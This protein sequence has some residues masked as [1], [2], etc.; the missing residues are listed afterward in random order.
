VK[1]KLFNKNIKVFA[2]PALLGI[3]ACFQLVI[4]GYPL[5]HDW[6]FELVRIVEYHEALSSGQVLPLWGGD[7]YR[8]FGSPIFIFYAPLYTACS[9]LLMMT[10]LSV[11]SAATIVLIFFSMLAAIGMAG[12][13]RAVLGRDKPGTDQASWVASAAYV[14]MPYFLADMLIRNASA[15]FVALCL[16]PYPLWG[17]ALICR[18]NSRGLPLLAISFALIIL[19]HNLLG[20]MMAS[21]LFI[22][23][24]VLFLSQRQFGRFFSSIAATVIS[25]G[26]SCWFWLPALGLKAQVRIDEMLQGK[27]DFHNSFSSPTEM[28]SYDGLF[29]IG[30]FLPAVIII[31]AAT[32]IRGNRRPIMSGLFGIALLLIFIQTAAC[33]LLWESIPFLPLF[34][35]PWRMMGPLALTVALIT[36]LLFHRYLSH[37]RAA[38]V[39]AILTIAI[40]AIPL[41]NRYQPLTIDNQK[42][43]SASMNSNGIRHR[44]LAATVL[45]EYLPLAASKTLTNRTPPGTIVIPSGTTVDKATILKVTSTQIHLEIEASNP[46]EIHLARWYFPGWRATLNGVEHPVLA[47]E[48][49]TIRVSIPSGKHQLKLW[50]AQPELR[51]WGMVISGISLAALILI[52]II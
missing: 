44:G 21:F 8:G 45:D 12:L 22:L 40:N 51:L 15:E 52:L 17:L 10:G 7:L 28:F 2:I 36:G 26:I 46:A 13:T 29:A 37:I 23:I 27:F 39:I 1:I 31:C 18:G 5:G 42:F 16:A 41:L 48:S 6:V 30:W 20:L 19:A 38:T 32:L 4:Y 9:S 43:I 24:P 3:A 33:T 14:L 49:G 11:T 35:F 34:Q 25:L 47:S 50:L